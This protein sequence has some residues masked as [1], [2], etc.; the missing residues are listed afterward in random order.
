MSNLVACSASG[1]IISDSA[2]SSFS[3]VFC[4]SNLQASN[5]YA[6]SGSEFSNPSIKPFNVMC[7][8]EKYSRSITRT[9]L[10]VI[11]GLS[12]WFFVPTSLN[13]RAASTLAGSAPNV[14]NCKSN[15]LCAYC[16]YSSLDLDTASSNIHFRC[17][18]PPENTTSFGNGA[19]VF[20]QW[21]FISSSHS[22]GVGF[23]IISG[24]YFFRSL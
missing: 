15:N 20:A 14:S 8:C 11:S 18:P 12:F 3:N 2:V 4:H 22:S 16:Q 10:F 21:T 23:A 5:S 24:W 1:R 19:F 9:F 7:I 6:F 17:A 13:T